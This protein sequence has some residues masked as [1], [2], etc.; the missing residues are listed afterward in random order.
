MYTPI[1]WAS[2]KNLEVIKDKKNAEQLNPNQMED[3]A[4][5][6]ENNKTR[7]FDMLYKTFAIKRVFNFGT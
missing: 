3:T 6:P 2:P 1:N 4:K 7:F 5:E